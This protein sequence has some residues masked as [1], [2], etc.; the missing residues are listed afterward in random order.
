MRNRF[1]VVLLLA[2]G[3][4]GMADSTSNSCVVTEGAW[5]GLVDAGF[6]SS[7][8]HIERGL[9]FA[10]R[11][12]KDE[13]LAEFSKAIAVDSNNAQAYLLRGGILLGRGDSMGSLLDFDMA[14]KLSPTNARA[15]A[16]RAASRMMSLANADAMP[17]LRRAIELDPSNTINYFSYADCCL[18][19]SL[20][21][22]A[23]KTYDAVVEMN[24][25]KSFVFWKRGQFRERVGSNALAIEDYMTAQRLDVSNRVPSIYLE[26]LY[27][28]LGSTDSVFAAGGQAHLGANDKGHAYQRG[29]SEVKAQESDRVRS[30]TARTTLD[31][32]STPVTDALSFLASCRR[33]DVIYEDSALQTNR[34]TVD[35]SATNVEVQVVLDWMLTVMDASASYEP[36]KVHIR[37]GGAPS[38][39]VEK[40][41]PRAWGDTICT[42][43]LWVVVEARDLLRILF[44]RPRVDNVIMFSRADRLSTKFKMPLRGRRN[45]DIL[46][47]VCKTAG[48]RCSMRGECVWVSDDD[49]PMRAGLRTKLDSTPPS[50][51]MDK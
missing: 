38:L 22:E 19:L 36:G 45:G 6:T 31:L 18:A 50:R 23:I 33:L 30:S 49:E 48:L 32:R 40:A 27:A 20:T 4:V 41:L 2:T 51:Q 39:Q 21:N 1:I 10:K 46:A 37:R 9:E 26:R 34:V 8:G 44:S 42:I 3:T 11:R 7:S 12:A 28:R 47:E 5:K 15:Y 13:A 25:E 16:A 17:D 14:V 43:D 29:A 35:I 24:P